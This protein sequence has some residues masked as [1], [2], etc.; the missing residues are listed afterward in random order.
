MAEV[1]LLSENKNTLNIIEMYN[2]V[3]PNTENIN[4]AITKFN[5]TIWQLIYADLEDAVTYED[6]ELLWLQFLSLIKQSSEKAGISYKDIL[7]VIDEDSKELMK[8]FGTKSDPKRSMIYLI[9]TNSEVPQNYTM[10]ERMII[11]TAYARFS[12]INLIF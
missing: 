10:T 9:G 2:E 1:I 4:L 6:F 8:E 11:L 12:G 7:Q 5:V 3:K